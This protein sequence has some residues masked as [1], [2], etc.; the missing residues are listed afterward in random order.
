M[1]TT[2]EA[3]ASSPKANRKLLMPRRVLMPKISKSCM[4]EKAAVKSV[5]HLLV[6]CG[7]FGRGEMGGLILCR[8]RRHPGG[9]C[10]DPMDARTC[11]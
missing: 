10:D 6:L 4:T 9:P 5:V 8:R 3:R 1:P 2:K 11:R 7:L